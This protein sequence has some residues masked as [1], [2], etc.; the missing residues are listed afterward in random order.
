MFS[1]L[2][3]FVLKRRDV[4][5]A[6]RGT[7]PGLG[8]M[9]SPIKLLAVT[10]SHRVPNLQIMMWIC[11]PCELEW[12]SFALHHWR[13]PPLMAT[14]KAMQLDSWKELSHIRGLQAKPGSFSCDFCVYAPVTWKHLS[15][16]LFTYYVFIF[17]SA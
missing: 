14:R 11:S 8:M 1:V 6:G 3:S 7:A 12:N 17:F 13:H 15:V 2:L 10:K 16:E 9:S 4:R 5:T